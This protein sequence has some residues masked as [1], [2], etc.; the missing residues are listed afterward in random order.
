M[1]AVTVSVAVMENVAIWG[2]AAPFSVI[3]KAWTPASVSVNVWSGG[4]VA[5]GLS[6]AACTVPE[7]PVATFPNWSFAVTVYDWVTPAVVEVGPLT[8]DLAAAGTRAPGHREVRHR[9]AVG[10]Q[11]P[12]HQR[13]RQRGADHGGLGVARDHHDRAGR[14]AVHA[15]P[16]SAAGRV[17]A[18]AVRGVVARDLPELAHVAGKSRRGEHEPA[19]QPSHV[20]LTDRRPGHTLHSGGRG[21]CPRRPRQASESLD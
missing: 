14:S 1:V 4:T 11:D 13:L 21:W 18:R 5:L 20:A 15:E 2:S 16:G 19:V 10:V 17:I 7:Y 6:V 9:V 12:D 3:G 8:T